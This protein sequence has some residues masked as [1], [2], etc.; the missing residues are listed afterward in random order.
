VSSFGANAHQVTSR[1]DL[2]SSLRDS[3][4]KDNGV[5]VIIA[6]VDY[7]EN[8]KL[9]NKLGKVTISL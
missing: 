7:R 8:M 9:I 2:V 1:S 4:T 3:M 5:N 6:P